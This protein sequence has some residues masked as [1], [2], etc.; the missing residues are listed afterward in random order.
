MTAEAAP[1][2][3]TLVHGTFARGAA[4]AN[5]DGALIRQRLRKRF[6]ESVRFRAFNWSGSNSHSARRVAAQALR[7]DQAAAAREHPGV[8]RFVIAH[9]HG[10]NVALHA[11]GGDAAA[12]GLAGIV[13]IGTPFITC[14][15][16]NLAAGMGL[17]RLGL[18][19]MALL[20]S[21]VLL[22][23]IA[24]GVLIGMG[25]LLSGT[26]RAIAVLVLAVYGSALAIHLA[27][28]VYRSMPRLEASLAARQR[29]LFALL[30]L[31]APPAPMLCVH[32]AGDEAGRWLGLTRWLAE[33]PY[34]V[35]RRATLVAMFLALGVASYLATLHG[36]S[37][38]GVSSHLIAA[39]V[40][41]LTSAM[42]V[43]AY[44]VYW[45]LVMA[46]VPL[47][48]RAHPGAYGGEGVFH[49]WLLR[50]RTSVLPAADGPRV[51]SYPCKAPPGMRGLRHSW[52]YGDAAV[53]D[54]VADWMAGRLSA[55]SRPSAD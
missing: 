37:G 54:A 6:G 49:N 5:D 9:S 51:T 16:R 26:A 35:W 31:P 24:A 50:I 13:T 43:L 12:P 30:R 10:G 48:V 44:G 18:P 45:Q 19:L 36:I 42:S 11:L 23:C 17:L 28:R 21:L 20:A 27:I 7:E 29:T 25:E 47:L 14:E 3:V 15:P 1:L 8:P 33:L 52:M 38:R 39:C 32:I 2:V 41:L 53:V 4:W 46:G 55:S 34:A 40:G 22:G